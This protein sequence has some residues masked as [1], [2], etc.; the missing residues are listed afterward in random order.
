[1]LDHRTLELPQVLAGVV[2]R[3]PPDVGDRGGWDMGS[4]PSVPHRREESAFR[5]ISLAADP[6][7]AAGPSSAVAAAVLLVLILLLY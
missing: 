3:W 2:D 7:L 4:V 6:S 1:M 5:W